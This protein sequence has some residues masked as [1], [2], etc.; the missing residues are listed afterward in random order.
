MGFKSEEEIDEWLSLEKERLEQ[1]FLS[2]IDKDVENTPKLKAKY[3]SGMKKLLERYELE[4]LS[5]L[6]KTKTRHK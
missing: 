2:G 6:K 5:L 4:S 1:D 3:D